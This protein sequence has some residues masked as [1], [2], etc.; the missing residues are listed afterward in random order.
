M[1]MYFMRLHRLVACI[2]PLFRALPLLSCCVC[3]FFLFGFWPSR[4]FVLQLVLLRSSIT[5]TS[6]SL[7]SYHND[8]VW[9]KTRFIFGSLF[10]GFVGSELAFLTSPR[11]GFSQKV[12]VLI[13][14]TFKCSTPAVPMRTSKPPADLARRIE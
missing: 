9:A 13:L 7:I 1:C 12:A 5:S 3:P 11:R 2:F 4:I 10:Y 8:G 6:P 14:C